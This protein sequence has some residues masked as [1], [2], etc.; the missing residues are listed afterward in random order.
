MRPP[1]DARKLPGCNISHARVFTLEEMRLA[2]ALVLGL[3]IACAQTCVP[4]RILPSDAVAGTLDDSSCLL[5]DGTPY[6]TYRLDLPVRGGIRI[7]LTALNADLILRDSSGTK[8]DSGASIRR[9]IE[10]GSYSLVVNG[11]A[12]GQA[13]PYTV[14]SAF[15]AE[16]GMWCSAFP[17]LGLNQ[18]VTATLGASG[19][20]MPDG[21]VYEGYLLETLGSGTLTVSV[22]S[23][24][25]STA[26]I[27][28]DSDGYAVASD[29]AQVSVPVD[30]NS[31]YQVVVATSD[32]SGS[33]RLASTFQPA[34]DETCRPRQSFTD[35]GSDTGSI[36]EGS[37]STTTPG[38]DPARYNFYTLT[39][40]QAG[41]ADLSVMSQ[42][43]AATLVLLDE[44][45][46]PIAADTGGQAEIRFPLKPGSYTAQVFSSLASEGGYTFTYQFTR[47]SPQP[48]T[49]A[50]AT[51]ADAIAGSLSSAS[52]RTSLGLADL[53]TYTLPASGTL[54]VT[55]AATSFPGLLAIRDAKDNLILLGRDG[56]GTGLS[57]LT[58]DLPAGS[59]TIVAGAAAGTGTYQMTSKF[60][61]H[62]IPP[63]TFLQ[64]LSI[65]GGYIQKLGSGS[66]RGPNG[67]AA[68]LYSFTMPSDGVVAGFLT[69]G[70]VD[71]VLT[72]TDSAGNFLRSDDNSYGGS[73]S[74]VVQFL[75][76]GDY[77]VAARAAGNSAGGYY[78]VDLRS[79]LTAR[80][81][82]CGS[83]GRLTPGVTIAGALSIASC[84]YTDSTFAD[85]YEMDLAADAT[86][87]VRLSSGDFDAYLVLLDA[88]GNVVDQDDDSGGNSDALVSR[89]LNAGVWFVVVKP[90]AGYSHIGAYSLS[91][92]QQ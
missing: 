29:A 78:E 79:V 26:L 17:R 39:V 47:G 46:N 57:Q 49:P 23:S 82:F 74:M 21:T 42:D 24:E 19:C 80:P 55:L 54:E 37:C 81:P 34:D 59:Y 2:V 10:S 51:P 43:F 92:G 12:P 67:Q 87:D 68:D 7:D 52:C 3:S 30:G 14:R 73:D 28:R 83:K 71:G 45:G 66:C 88:R 18:T 91:L 22:S 15:T 4:S 36:T 11:R 31:R 41:L 72:L 16:P 53:Y 77:Q 75:P 85:V 58:A 62:D 86:V 48:C 40:G 33:Y 6:T 44:A 56:E 84:Q 50:A 69:S 90:S 38:G 89:A 25:F 8:V 5:S 1:A 13:V 61:P 35:S 70:Q 60:T 76:A 64:P 27:L 65:N 9:P 32:Q 63:C 20:A